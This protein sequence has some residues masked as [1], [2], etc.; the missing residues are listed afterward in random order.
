MYPEAVERVRRAAPGD[1][2]DVSLTAADLAGLARAYLDRKAELDVRDVGVEIRPPG[3]LIRGVTALLAR[4]CGSACW[5]SPRP[6]IAASAS[7]SAAWTS[8][9][10]PRR[11]SRPPRSGHF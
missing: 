2:L 10:R 1:P 9:A 4:T 5:G 6:K 3:V 11:S 8:T 7:T